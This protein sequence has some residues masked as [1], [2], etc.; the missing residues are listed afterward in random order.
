MPS[1]FK[2]PTFIKPRRYSRST[3]AIVFLLYFIILCILL[4]LQI[5]LVPVEHDYTQAT[6]ERKQEANTEIKYIHEPY[7]VCNGLVQQQAHSLLILVKSDIAN[8]AQRLGA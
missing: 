7:S 2:C 4:Y 8:I 5:R 3:L 6:H 1:N